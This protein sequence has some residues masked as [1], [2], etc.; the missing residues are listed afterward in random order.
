MKTSLKLL[1]VFVEYAESNAILLI[2]AV[3][4]VDDTRN[5]KPWSNIMQI[6]GDLSNQDDLELI[7]Y[8]MILI[9][10]VLNSIPDQDTFYDVSDFFEEQNMQNIIKH[11]QK[12]Q[13]KDEHG[14]A[15]QIVQQMDLYEASLAQEDG[16][17]ANN[18]DLNSSF[19][20]NSTSSSTNNKNSR[21]SLAT[22][23]RYCN[24]IHYF[25]FRNLFFLYFV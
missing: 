20:S 25:F 9:N 10:T 11:Y 7:L 21:D 12:N 6:L 5:N 4:V 16:E 17:D 8:S 3:N 19:S 24:I 18:D 23:L 2:Q 22:N 13:I 1:I 15:K 14:L